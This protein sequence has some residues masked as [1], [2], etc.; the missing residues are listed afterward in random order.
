MSKLV[1]GTAQFGAGYGI[2]NREGR[3]SDDSVRAILDVAD[4]A[5]LFLLDT[6]PDYGDA[7]E[8]LGALAGT[9]RRPQYVSK[10][11]L[12]SSGSGPIDVAHLFS[13]SLDALRVPSLYGL[14]FHRVAD[15]RD[16]RAADV[17]NGLRE[18]RNRGTLERIGVSIYDSDD[19]EI[20]ARD[21]T[22]LDIIQ[23]PGN[24]V[25]RR[26][27]DHPALETL[28]A[29]GAEVHVRSAYLQ[30]LLLAEPADLPEY[31]ASLRPAV[32]SIRERAISTE[33]SPAAVC[34][35]FLAGHPSVDRIVVGSTSAA[36][37]AAT[38]TAFDAAP[39]I[40]GLDVPPADAE[41]LDPRTW[42]P[43]ED[44]Q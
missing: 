12:P 23:V 41:L 22:D 15:L 43:R 29:N 32:E 2:T 35:S 7:Q 10:F 20:V 26:L 8:R 17:W 39:S 4:A 28:H 1:L 31:F 37:L 42:P 27:L 38:I 36:E 40:A 30:G 16:H 5:G 24:V 11:T 14:L 6:A 19:L 9:G 33:T 18:A 34:L 3:I 25:D 44:L 13:R 21:F